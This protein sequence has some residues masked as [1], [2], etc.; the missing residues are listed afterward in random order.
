MQ[1]GRK[2]NE[3][4]R[5]DRNPEKIVVVDSKP[6]DSCLRIFLRREA[7]SLLFVLVIT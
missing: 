1:N 2:R 6:A 7:P 5:P 4:T 3:A